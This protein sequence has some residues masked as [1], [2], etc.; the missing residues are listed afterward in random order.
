MPGRSRSG[1]SGRSPSGCRNTC[2]P[3]RSNDC[4]EESPVAPGGVVAVYMPAADESDPDLNHVH[5]VRAHA[6]EREWCLVERLLLDRRR[7]V[8]V[9]ARAPQAHP[10]REQVPLPWVGADRVAEAR[11]VGSPLEPVAAAVL[12]VGPADGKLA[13]RLEV[14]VDDRPVPNGRSENSIPTTAKRTDQAVECVRRDDGSARFGSIGASSSTNCLRSSTSVSS[15]D[16]SQPTRRLPARL[17]LRRAWRRSRPADPRRRRPCAGSRQQS[18]E[19][20]R[21]LVGWY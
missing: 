18:F 7:A 8:A 14:V 16:G 9:P 13:C 12:P 1:P 11:L 21:L 17:P 15:R 5:L 3:A 4:G 2:R 20:E 10:R 19:A 6:D